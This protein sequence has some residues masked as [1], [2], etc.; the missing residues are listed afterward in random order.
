MSSLLEMLAGQLGGDNLSMISKEIGADEQSTKSALGAA[1]PM[2]IGAL[3]RNGENEQGAQGIMNALE[4]AKPDGSILDNLGDFL[5]QK[6]YEEPRSG[7]GI[8]GHILGGKQDRVRQGVSQA[9]G[10]NSDATGQLMKMLAPMVLGA[11]GKKKQ[12]SSGMGISDLMGLLG[13]EKQAVEQSAGG[14]LIGR[15]LD[16]DGDGD[17]DMGDIA[18]LAMGKLFG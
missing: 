6:K 16:Q 9:S 11:L 5:G 15:M 1:L 10:L 7:A 8:L 18:K 12:Q 17:F 3:S 13:G 4:K 2:L 14:S